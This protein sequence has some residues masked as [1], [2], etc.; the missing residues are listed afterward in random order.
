M[1]V[2]TNA[3]LRS[4][5]P[6]GITLDPATFADASD[7]LPAV[8]AFL[9][10]VEEAQVAQ[11]ATA[12]AGEDVQIIGTGLGAETTITRNNVTHQVRQV[13]RTVTAFEKYTVSEVFPV[14]V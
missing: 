1:A 14:L 4:T 9:K 2:I 8:I 10:A 3:N 6:A 7:C 11:N 13:T 5:L 12:P